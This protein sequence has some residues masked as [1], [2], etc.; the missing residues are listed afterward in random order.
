M[1]YTDK[2]R[3]VIT[4]FCENVDCKKKFKTVRHNKKFCTTK[5]QWKVWEK[6][7]PRSLISRKELI[8]F[9]NSIKD[10]PGPSDVSWHICYYQMKE[11]IEI[12]I[13]LLETRLQ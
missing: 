2:D 5:C 4:K 3:D 8:E 13:S 1:G 10:A 6:S 11:K 7:H 9:K 12:F